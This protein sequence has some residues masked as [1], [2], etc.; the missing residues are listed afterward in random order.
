MSNYRLPLK[1]SS[2]GHCEGAFEVEELTSS[3]RNIN[4]T[5]LADTKEF[6][7]KNEEGDFQKELSGDTKSL[8][9]SEAEESVTDQFSYK[10]GFDAGYEVGKDEKNSEER[11]QAFNQGRLK[12]MQDALEEI[13]DKEEMLADLS[14]TAAESHKSYQEKEQCLSI[15]VEALENHTEDISE[16]AELIAGNVIVKV[17]GEL[18]KRR[19]LSERFLRKLVA[20]FIVE[21][22]KVA[23]VSVFLGSKIY[24]LA[25]S[26]ESISE[27]ENF[28]LDL[29]LDEFEIEI[30][31]SGGFYSIDFK[32]YL[33]GL[34]AKL[35]LF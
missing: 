26:I 7:S 2:S 1:K 25:S 22:S 18:I 8:I 27:N 10:K 11:E 35:E 19:L 20:S 14:R 29:E 31:R 21:N 12:G 3:D 9:S 28:E 30:R 17:F 32:K 6:L 24:K 16:Q 34:R 33:E 23:N 15:L 4:S 5:E 13:K